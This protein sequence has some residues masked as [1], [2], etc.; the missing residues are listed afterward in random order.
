LLIAHR[1]LIRVNEVIKRPNANHILTNRLY[2]IQ[3]APKALLLAQGPPS[4]SVDDNDDGD[5]VTGPVNLAGKTLLSMK[6]DWYHT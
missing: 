6:V 3:Y 4:D 1:K 2:A 5:G